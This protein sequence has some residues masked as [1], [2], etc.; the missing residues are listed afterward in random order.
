MVL[1]TTVMLAMGLIVL[2]DQMKISQNAVKI[3]RADILQQ[4]VLMDLVL[5][6]HMM[7]GYLKQSGNLKANLK[8]LFKDGDIK[9]PNIYQSNKH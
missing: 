5:L 8:K 9:C 3:I 7:L 2:T 1:M 4:F 6:L